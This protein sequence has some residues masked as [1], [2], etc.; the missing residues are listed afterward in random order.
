MSGAGWEP[1]GD[2]EA[3]C[4]GGVEVDVMLTACKL[5]LL[6]LPLFVPLVVLVLVLVMVLSEPEVNTAPPLLVMRR[7]RL[8]G[9]RSPVPVPVPAAVP[10]AAAAALVRPALPGLVGD[11]AARAAVA[12]AA[13]EI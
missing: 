8:L 13:A 7:D 3:H 10:A 4:D 9:E 6:L 1:N 2:C 5:L 12:A 11:L